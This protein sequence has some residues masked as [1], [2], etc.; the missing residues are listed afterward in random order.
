M[1]V[2]CIASDDFHVAF[3]HRAI[4]DASTPFLY[5]DGVSGGGT[6]SWAF[7]YTSADPVMDQVV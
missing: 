6:N 3:G 1:E 7:G 2:N 4:T 5:C